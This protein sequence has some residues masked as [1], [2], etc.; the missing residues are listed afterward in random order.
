MHGAPFRNMAYTVTIPSSG[1]Q[2][3]VEAG[4]TILQAGLR[5]GIRLPHGCRGGL[6]GACLSRIIAGRIAYPQ[7][8]P[9]ALV[10]DE[11]MENNG[12]CCV[13]FPASDLVIEPLNAGTDWE[14]WAQS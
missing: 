5:Q 14:P 1:E 3:T 2:F 4:E 6:C 7:G 10:D 12:L 8:P 9:P 11:I 13:G